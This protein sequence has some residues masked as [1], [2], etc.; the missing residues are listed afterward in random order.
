MQ[1]CHG[2]SAHILSETHIHGPQRT[3]GRAG[4]SCPAFLTDTLAT[5]LIHTHTA[6]PKNHNIRV[7]MR[8]L[9]IATPKSPFMTFAHFR[10]LLFIPK[11]KYFLPGTK[12]KFF[13]WNTQSSPDTN[14][15]NGSEGI[16]KKKEI[17][18]ATT[19]SLAASNYHQLLPFTSKPKLDLKSLTPTQTGG[20]PQPGQIKSGSILPHQF[21]I[22][23]SASASQPR[24]TG[25]NFYT[26]P[27]SAKS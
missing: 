17:N 20:P 16:V 8:S 19:S 2:Q 12:K 18:P 23:P 24:L 15:R 26:S 3:P 21:G 7:T 5:I 22:T 6:A 13:L 11:N 9:T 27:G 4:N 25:S 10:S 14:T 1:C